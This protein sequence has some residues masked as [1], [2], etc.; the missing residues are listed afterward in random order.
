MDIYSVIPAAFLVAM[1]AGCLYAF[2]KGW[3]PGPGGR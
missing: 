3:P 1:T 2:A